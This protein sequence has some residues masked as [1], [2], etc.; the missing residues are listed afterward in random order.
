MRVYVSELEYVCVCS[1]EYVCVGVC[2]S[3]QSV[4]ICMHGQGNLKKMQD[5]IN[6]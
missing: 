3:V 2:Y 4:I 6:M 1:S 5:P